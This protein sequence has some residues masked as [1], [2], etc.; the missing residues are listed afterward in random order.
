MTIELSRNK[1]AEFKTYLQSEG[2]TFETRPHQ[3]FL[4]RTEGLVVN[5]YNSGKIVLAGRESFIKQKVE[6]FLAGQDA[7]QVVRKEKQY[8]EINVTGNRIGTDEAGKGDYFGP[9]VIA[10]ALV[11]ESQI[12]KLTEAG[13]R[14]S[15]TMNDNSI[16]KLASEIKMLIDDDQ[17]EIITIPP[18]KYNSLQETME[19]LNCILGWGHAKAIETLLGGKT[20]CEVAVA[21]QFGDERYIKNALMK[22]GSKI[23]LIQVHKAEREIAVAAASILARCEFVKQMNKLGERYGTQFP[24]GATH[25]IT[26]AQNFVR[27]YGFSELNNVAKVHFKTTKKLV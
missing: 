15:K 8:S 25:V 17:Y 13:I 9:L 22:K 21:D 1:F 26:F 18:E 14:D 23:K 6:D 24:K 27:K 5:L 12:K 19:N 7:K 3:Y 11:T 10:G 20:K 16:I 4:A 2:F